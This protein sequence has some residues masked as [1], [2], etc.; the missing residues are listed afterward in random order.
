MMKRD[1]SQDT[2]YKN[3]LIQRKGSFKHF[4]TKSVYAQQKAIRRIMSFKNCKSIC[5]PDESLRKRSLSKL[6]DT[7]Y[8]LK[9]IYINPYIKEI[10]IN[11]Y[12]HRGSAPEIMN[13]SFVNQQTK[14]LIL[15]KFFEY[16]QYCHHFA[17]F[18][19]LIK[20]YMIS[21]EKN[22]GNKD[23]ISVKPSITHALA[24]QVLAQKLDNFDDLKNNSNCSIDSISGSYNTTLSGRQ[25]DLQ[26][27]IS[28]K[29]S[30][31]S[32]FRYVKTLKSPESFGNIQQNI[33]ILIEAITA[34]E[35]DDIDTLKTLISNNDFDV[36]ISLKSGLYREFRQ[37]IGLLD[38]ALM[39]G[40]Y[41]CANLLL[42]SGATIKQ[43]IDIVNRRKIVS[44]VKKIFEDKRKY[45]LE[46]T[47]DKKNED[48][49]EVY[50]FVEQSKLIKKMEEVL[51]QD[52]TTGHVIDARV[53]VSSSST[54]LFEFFPPPNSLGNTI[55]KYKLEWSLSKT[56]DEII[57]YKII[58][59]LRQSSVEIDNLIHG[60]SYCFRIT[61]GS[62]YG[63]GIPII[64]N[65]CP[66]TISSWED[67]D[68]IIIG[69][70]IESHQE[71]INV[72]TKDVEKFKNSIVWQTIFP[73]NNEV[74]LKKKSSR[75]RHLFS[76]SKKFVKNVQK[77][78]YLA[79]IIYT[80]DKILCTVDDALPII[81]IDEKNINMSKDDMKWLIKLSRCWNQLYI[82][83]DITNI[84]SSNFQFRTSIIDSIN[85]MI[86][87]LGVKDIGTV[88]HTPIIFEKNET[89]FIVTVRYTFDGQ[90]SQG[91]A[92]KW[93][94]LNK[95]IRKKTNCPAIDF[96][97][98]EIINILNFYESYQIPLDRGLY[99]CYLKT[100]STLNSVNLI[101][102]ENLPN[103]LPFV[104]VR[105]NPHVSKEEWEWIQMLNDY[106]PFEDDNYLNCLNNDK[107]TI[108][109]VIYL[110]SNDNIDNDNVN[111]NNKKK[112]VP[113]YAQKHFQEKIYRSIQIFLNDL[114]IS[115]SKMV[116]H[117]LYRLRIF[118][119]HPD[120]SMILIVPNIEEVCTMVTDNKNL[121]ENM[122]LLKSCQTIPIPIFEMLHL[123]TYQ[124]KFM[125]TFCQLSIFIEHYLGITQYEYRKC[126]IDRDEKV[127]KELFN[128]LNEFK[129]KLENI[130][131]NAKWISN[132]TTIARDPKKKSCFVDFSKISISK[133]S[134]DTHKFNLYSDPESNNNS[135][136][137]DLISKKF[138]NNA[139][140]HKLGKEYALTSN[141]FLNNIS[142]ERK[143]KSFSEKSNAIFSFDKLFINDNKRNMYRS[144]MTERQKHTSQY[145]KKN[146]KDESSLRIR[147]ASQGS[148]FFKFRSKSS[149][150]DIHVPRK[151]CLARND[152]ASIVSDY[153]YKNTIDIT[154]KEMKEFGLLRVHLAFSYCQ[155]IGASIRLRVTKNT[156]CKEVIS[157]IVKQLNHV[158]PKV[159]NEG[160]Y[161]TPEN[162]IKNNEIKDDIYKEE[163]FCL[164]AVLGGRERRL[165]N[166]FQPLKLSSPWNK[167]KLYIR[168]INTPCEAIMCGNEVLV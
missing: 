130:W 61:A 63:D 39:L 137:N 87:A 116:D 18:S 132:I 151:G 67:V 131:K 41:K 156:T 14:I 71:A 75:L 62:I 105:D 103:S 51:G 81:S 93:I 158:K 28:E 26:N 150:S 77:G 166:E 152:T 68:N 153:D 1:L 155:N 165:R 92:T 141:I 23:V 36:N 17:V 109:D 127:Y 100:F 69:N 25:Y 122:E 65:P 160:F 83:H 98:N 49:K 42:E 11:N 40:H 56:F 113:T 115:S 30:N 129:N 139:T 52:E 143:K 20:P 44:E 29:S 114:G 149:K 135:H 107:E 73:T 6:F 119:L 34:V 5:Y 140:L 15:D 16:N 138:V 88:H 97:N 74:N 112:I 168:H 13:K 59:D 163:N 90:I 89:I 104:C 33:L 146:N 96:L 84:Q 86:N 85:S 147:S 80:T 120:V 43:D 145:L 78:I 48:E 111:T 161:N 53:Y 32:S 148:N 110:K 76:A 10:G 2:M 91:L 50:H 27:I 144:S 58:Y 99:L 79:S 3:S 19:C 47:N 102:P 133:K 126:I 95:I 108:N 9:E 82:L 38:V 128:K 159:I 142:S 124:P 123:S 45:F 64:A 125:T 136:F 154:S 66:I 94:T 70:D 117:R 54:V 4:V 162:N 8:S 35:V 46:K 106:I 134:K 12:Y 57:D 60:N 24:T 118:R 164:V 21:V 72:L 121:V 101:V 22:Q 31:T 7:R 167:G 157:L 55:I 37:K